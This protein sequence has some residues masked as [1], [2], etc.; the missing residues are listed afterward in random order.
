MACQQ[1]NCLHSR[2]RSIIHTHTSL[3]SLGLVIPPLPESSVALITSALGLFPPNGT[4]SP[5]SNYFTG[6]MG[7][8]M[9]VPDGVSVSNNKTY[10]PV[11]TT[12]Y[13]TFLWDIKRDM[14]PTRD[15]YRYRITTSGAPLRTIEV[16]SSASEDDDA[17]LTY[18]WVL[19]EGEFH[20]Y[21]PFGLPQRIYYAS[22]FPSAICTS[23][24]QQRCLTLEEDYGMRPRYYY[25]ARQG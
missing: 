19:V 4:S 7:C 16:G 13:G 11:N 20:M 22:H 1:P 6:W 18:R 25:C 2:F 23:P 3:A 17:H 8:G 21:L 15:E 5:D 14:T 24:T 10:V 9:H 12:L